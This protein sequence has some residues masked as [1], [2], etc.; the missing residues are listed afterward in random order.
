MDPKQDLCPTRQHIY[1]NGH[2][3]VAFGEDEW[4]S[5]T[6]FCELIMINESGL[7][8]LNSIQIEQ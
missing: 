5:H 1:I 2:R 3:V 6:D 4:E 7:F 8:D